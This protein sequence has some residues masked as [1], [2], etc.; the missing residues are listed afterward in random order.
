[1]EKDVPSKSRR[2]YVA[3]DNWIWDFDYNIR[4]GSEKSILQ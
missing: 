2:G 3:E 4:K 1:L